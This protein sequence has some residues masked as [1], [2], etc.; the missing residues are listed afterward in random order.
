MSPRKLDNQRLLARIREHH[1]ASDGVMGMPRMHELLTDQGETAS[2]NRIARL[3]AGDGLFGIPQ[4]RQWRRKRSGVRPAFVRNHL[5]RDFSAN[6]PNRKWVIDI[7]YIHTAEGW[8]YLCVVVDLYAGLV[9]RG[10]PRAPVA[11]RR[12]GGWRQ[13]LD[14]FCATEAVRREPAPGIGK[15]AGDPANHDGDDGQG[16]ER[17]AWRLLGHI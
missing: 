10:A 16:G 9:A 3:M 12:S 11:E 13:G 1:A 17:G 5:E 8:L 15:G 4:R 14:Q 7:T 2:R 6:E